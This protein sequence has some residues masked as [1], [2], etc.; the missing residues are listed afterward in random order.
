MG[1]YSVCYGPHGKKR[2]HPDFTLA[3]KDH[4]HFGLSWRGAKKRTTFWSH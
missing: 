4:I 3:H 1:P 2:K